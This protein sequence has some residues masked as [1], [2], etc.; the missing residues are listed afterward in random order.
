MDVNGEHNF[1]AV[2]PLGRRPGTYWIGSVVVYSSLFLF[3]YPR[4]NFSSTLYPQS[5]R[6]VTYNLHLKNKLNK[7]SPQNNILLFIY[8]VSREV[9]LHTFMSTR[10]PG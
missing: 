4:C 3:A 9:F 1:R 8:Y 5:S 7:C 6:S 2:V 10:T